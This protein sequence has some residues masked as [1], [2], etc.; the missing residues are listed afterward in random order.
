MSVVDVD[1][2][3]QQLMPHDVGLVAHHLVGPE[4]QVLHADVLLGGVRGPV[5]AAVP[6]PRQGH[7]GLAQGLRRDGAGAHAHA[8]DAGRAL[9]HGDLL[10]QLGRLD[11]RALTTRARPDRDQ[12][13]V[14]GC[15]VHGDSIGH[16]TVDRSRGVMRRT[17]SPGPSNSPSPWTGV[18]GLRRAQVSLRNRSMNGD[19]RLAHRVEAR[20]RDL[21][22]GVGAG[23]EVGVVPVDQVDRRHPRLL[24]GRVVVVDQRTGGVGERG[25]GPDLAGGGAEPAPQARVRRGLA[26]DAQRAVGH[27]VHEHHRAQLSGVPRR[28]DAAAA[29]AVG[30]EVGR[31]GRLLLAVEEHETHLALAGPPALGEIPREL[32]HHGG[33][34]RA[35]VGAHESGE[36]LGVV[37]G[38]DEDRLPAAG[39]APRDVAQTARHTLVAAA[40]ELGAQSRRETPRGHRAGRAGTHVDLGAQ[41]GEG[42][43][44]VEAVRRG[45]A[46]RR[47]CT[48]TRTRP[49]GSPRSPS[50]GRSAREAGAGAWCGES[51][52]EGLGAPGGCH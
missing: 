30:E 32:H 42:A 39:Q 22:E 5:E 17:V 7:R 15:A 34:A 16:R 40:G 3:A 24:E 14:E 23:V 49:A 37:V 47:R 4:D 12:V 13:E 38:G 27:E 25:P 21:V 2:V 31:S 51:H 44:G 9:D 6:V 50:A 45:A 19:Q 46:G 48:P 28:V 52:A 20:G 36:V 33:A 29:Q 18:Q 11:G 8:P 43:V 41:L 10:A 1:V 26:R 35:V